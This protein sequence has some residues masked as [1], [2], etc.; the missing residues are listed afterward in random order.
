M[1]EISQMEQMKQQ[2][3]DLLIQINTKLQGVIDQLNT[4]S[5]NTGTTINDHEK[6]IRNLERF[7]AIAFGGILILQFILNMA[8]K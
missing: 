7:G 1:S 6:R 2:D 5:K 8:T 4:L 3:H